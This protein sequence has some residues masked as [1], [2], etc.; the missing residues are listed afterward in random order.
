[1]FEE[2]YTWIKNTRIQTKQMCALVKLN[3]HEECT[4][5]EPRMTTMSELNE[6]F[7]ENNLYISKK[8]SHPN[9]QWKMKFEIGTENSTSET[10]TLTYKVITLYD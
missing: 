3:M 7:S 6:M 10:Y 4:C 2:I 9:D 5:T 8:C 1:M